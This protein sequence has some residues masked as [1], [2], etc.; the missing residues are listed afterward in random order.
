[1]RDQFGLGS[2]TWVPGLR[3]L[4]HT[5]FD[6]YLHGLLWVMYVTVGVSTVVET[7]NASESTP[8]Y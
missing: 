4:E 7:T 5:M 3:L 2:S 1:M 8:T 6:Q